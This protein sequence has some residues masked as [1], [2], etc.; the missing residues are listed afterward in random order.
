MDLDTISFDHSCWGL[1]DPCDDRH[2]KIDRLQKAG[3]LNKPLVLVLYNA[4][5]RSVRSI[6]R[7]T[8]SNAEIRNLLPTPENSER[9]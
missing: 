2:A 7:K 5:G 9:D 4:L 6:Y 3:G 1:K 8:K